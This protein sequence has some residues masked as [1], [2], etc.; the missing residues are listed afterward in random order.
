[1][2]FDPLTGLVLLCTGVD[3]PFGDGSLLSPA[4]FTAEVTSLV[5]SE[6]DGRLVDHGRY[7]RLLSIS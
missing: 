4:G 7:G 6:H 5:S 1:M 2:T 3:I